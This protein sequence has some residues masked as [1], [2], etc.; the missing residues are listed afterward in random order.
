MTSSP[1]V[2][3]LKPL[4]S[5]FREGLIRGVISKEEIVAWADQRI[6]EADEPDYFLIE[7]S[8]SRDINGLVEV[9][10]KHVEPTDDPIYIRTLLGHI[11]HKQPIYDINEVEN[12]AALVG[13]LYSPLKLTAFENSTIYNFDEYVIFYLPDST[14]L[15]VEL[16]NFLSMYKAFTLDNYD[17][18]ADINEQVLELLKVE[19]AS[20]EEL[21]ELIFRAKL[22]KDK[23][24]KWRRKLVAGA[25]LLVPFGFGIIV[26]KVVFQ[27][28]DNRLLLVGSGSCFLAMLGRQLLQK[29]EK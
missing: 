14:Q 29:S 15:Q 1:Q 23:R 22:K 26:I 13:S 4:L 9:F 17:Q 24:R 12:I 11:Y 6:E 5:V 18:W 16:I 3:D 8:L 28:S 21:D 25:L 2:Q 27:P 7:I 19:E 10:N 20:A